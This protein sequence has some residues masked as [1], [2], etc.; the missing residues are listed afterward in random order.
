LGEEDGRCTRARREL[1]M[2]YMR[3]RREST[4]GSSGYQMARKW[5][6]GGFTVAVPSSPIPVS[7]QHQFN[8]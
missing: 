8:I 1:D 5:P 3:A 2:S 4:A 6:A 7:F